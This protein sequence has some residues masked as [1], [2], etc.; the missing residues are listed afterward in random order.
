MAKSETVIR[1][2][3]ELADVQING[4]RPWDM[5]VH[6]ERLYDRILRDSSLGLGEAYMEGWWDCEFDRRVY[7]P[8]TESPSRRKDPK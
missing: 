2:L 8:G 4:S 3:C 5:Q 6:D 1:E 7:Q